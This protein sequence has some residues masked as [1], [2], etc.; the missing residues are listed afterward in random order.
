[1]NAPQV[2]HSVLDDSLLPLCEAP[3]WYVALSGGLDS[4]VLLNLVADWC[5]A[6]PQAPPLAAIHVEHG[7]A[8]AADD[9]AAHCAASCAALEVPCIRRPV[10]VPAGASLEARARSARYAR[11]QEVL[12]AGEVL[13]L[14][15]HLDDQVETF[16]L[17][18][19]RGAG[20]EG[21][22]AM[23]ARRPLGAGTLVRPLLAYPR[24]ALEACARA[25]GLT[26][27]EDPSN[28]DTR[29]DRNFLRSQVLPLLAQRWPGYRATIARA[30]EHLGAAAVRL[31]ESAGP[32]PTCTSVLGDPGLELAPL[33][34]GGEES[35]ATLLRAALA[36]WGCRAPD[37]AALMEFLR[38]LQESGEESS[39]ELRMADCTL[40][41]FQGGVFR[42]P[43]D[44]APTQAFEITPGEVREVPG[45]GR[46]ALVPTAGEG[47]ALAPGEALAVRFRGGG[48]HCRVR[49]RASA[50]LKKLLQEWR[51]PPWWRARLPLLYSGGE[52]VGVAD[53]ALCE[54]TRLLDAGA[55]G[56]R[57][58]L[59]WERP[60]SVRDD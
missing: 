10:V 14:A 16:M 48:E 13:F 54:S 4:T 59:A 26:Y 40:R 18:L 20:L 15:H 52:L 43:G 60:D 58:I 32:L 33:L 2:D 1:M 30:G 36:L 21:L 50:P 45:V 24:D 42:V 5:R 51:I 37:R 46:L 49:G 23:P 38:Q 3:R 8:A 41:R 19:M 56:E 11:F 27:V 6:H 9:W 57:W 35:A 39:P 31:R 22:A 29:F 53:I 12:G 55:S 7:L 25:R 44:V 17:R 28:T 34:A 47:I